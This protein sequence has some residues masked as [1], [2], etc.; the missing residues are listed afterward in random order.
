MADPNYI[1]SSLNEGKYLVE[2]T[3]SF[4]EMIHLIFP[5]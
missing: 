2:C 3:N 4:S 5:R 1:R